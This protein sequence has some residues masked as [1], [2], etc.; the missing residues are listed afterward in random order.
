MDDVFEFLDRL[1][2]K[3]LKYKNKPKGIM[4]NE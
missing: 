2:E 3:K 4:K 1:L